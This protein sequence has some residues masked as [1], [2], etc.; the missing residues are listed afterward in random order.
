MFR[1]YDDFAP[2]FYIVYQ[3]FVPSN[4]C[5]ER[6]VPPTHHFIS[7]KEVPHVFNASSNTIHIFGLYT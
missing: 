7:L 4:V 5:S 6:G 3:G 1:E 2:Y